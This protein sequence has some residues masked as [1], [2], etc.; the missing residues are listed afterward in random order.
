VHQLNG[1]LSLLSPLSSYMYQWVQLRETGST[2]LVA[3]CSLFRPHHRRTLNR[4]F[5]APAIFIPNEK[6]APKMESTY[7]AD[8]W[9]VC[10]GYYTWNTLS[11]YFN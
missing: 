11:T 9:S 4:L 3:E 10:H 5:S 8:F 7:G 2:V 6:P 1:Q